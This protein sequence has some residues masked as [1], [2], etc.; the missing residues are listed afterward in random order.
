MNTTNIPKKITITGVSSGAE[1]NAEGFESDADMLAYI[2]AAYCSLLENQATTHACGN[3]N[4]HF[5]KL[6]LGIRDAVV[7]ATG[8]KKVEAKKKMK[9]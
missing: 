1:V 9:K 2:T 5:K 6:T 4:C 3:K 8:Y 7:E